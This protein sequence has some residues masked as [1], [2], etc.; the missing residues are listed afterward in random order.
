MA[1]IILITEEQYRLITASE[2]HG[3][4]ASAT[5]D[6]TTL[7]FVLRKERTADNGLE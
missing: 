4:L 7:Y 6:G 2:L 1:S 3:I 5:T